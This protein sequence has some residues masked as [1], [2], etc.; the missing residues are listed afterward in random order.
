MGG[1][2][3]NYRRLDT[4]FVV[5]RIY[6]WLLRAFGKNALFRDVDQVGP[7]D[8]FGAAIDRALEQSAV[9]VVVVGHQWLDITDEDGNRKLDRKDDFVRR[10]IEAAILRGIHLLPVLLE[11]AHLPKASDIPKSIRVLSNRDWFVLRPDPEFADGMRR[12]INALSD[13]VG[14]R[15]QLTP[16]GL[17]S[18]HA[19]GPE[20]L[21]AWIRRYAT[22]VEGKAPYWRFRF[23]G[24]SAF[25]QCQ[26]NDDLSID[27][28]RVVAPVVSLNEADKLGTTAPT[29][30]ERM[31]TAN[32]HSALDPRYALEYGIVMSSFLHPLSTI[33]EGQF[34]SALQQV[35]EMVWTFGTSFSSSELVYGSIGGL[36]SGG[37]E[38]D[39]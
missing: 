36:G 18:A 32:Y 29:L 15:P 4:Q 9:V 1:I 3:I 31:L 7:G 22:T 34:Y 37:A 39:G 30:L 24:R 6:G 35:T 16:G 28:M 21:D 14:I 8:D 26:Q 5:D 25:C 17:V 10:E 38:D 2:F 23:A 12:L 33:G 11:G 20:D 27:R 13:T 19:T